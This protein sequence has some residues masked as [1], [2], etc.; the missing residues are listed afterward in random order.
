MSSRRPTPSTQESLPSGLTA[1]PGSRVAASLTIAEYLLPG[2]LS[3][4]RVRRP[5]VQINLIGI[6]SAAVAQLVL[7][8]EVDLGFIEG[9][10]VP[11]GLSARVVGQDRLVVVAAPDH[12]WARRRRPLSPAELAST[13]LVQR[14]PG[15]GT[16]VAFEHALRGHDI[17]TPALELST[18]SAVR[19]AA[20]AGAA[21]TVASAFAIGDD[22]KARRLVEIPVTGLDLSRRLRAVWPRGQRLT[23]PARDLLGLISKSV[24][25]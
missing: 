22:L 7:D 24:N 18:A 10:Q 1:K 2:W 17:A 9:P 25:P 11:P 3:R 19:G 4:W 14:E 13:P 6:N 8:G 15:S 5:D 23:G 12:P 21:P 16:R 20:A